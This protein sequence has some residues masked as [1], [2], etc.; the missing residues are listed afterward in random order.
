MRL[1]TKATVA[2]AL[3]L[4][5]SAAVLAHV[6]LIHPSNGAKLYWSSPSNISV[7]INDQGSDNITDGSHETA[8]RNAIEEWNKIEGTTLQLVENT[9]AASQARTDWES[10]SIHLLY[11]DENNSSGYFP[12]GSSTV[13]ITPVWFYS[14]GRISDA[15]VLFNGNSFSFTTSQ[16]SGRYDVQD[17]AVHELGHV[18]GLDHTGWAG[19]SMYPYV[20]STVIL[21]RSL[22]QDEWRGMRGIYPSGSHAS[23]SG[24]VRRTSD[25]SVVKGATVF[26]RDSNGRTA[27]AD[28]SSETGTFNI[29]GLPADTYTI[30]VRP[31]DYPV[32]SSNLGGSRTIQTDFEATV[33]GSQVVGAGQSQAIGD[34]FVG[35]DVSISLGRS[36][37]RYPLRIAAGETTNLTIRGNGLNAGSTLSCSDPAISIASVNWFGS[38]VT[39]L[40]SVPGGAA[41]G[42]VDVTVVDSVGDTSILPGGLEVT[43]PDP[44]VSLAS[45]NQGDFNGG[46]AVTISGTNFNAGARVVFGGEIYEDGAAGGCTVLNT[47][48]ISLTTRASAT[49]LTDVVV[50]D[51]SG[52]E[53]RQ[54]DGFQFVMA[55]SITTVFP[56][57]GST[58]GSTE[59]RINGENFDLASVVR[60]NGVNQAAVFPVSS[61]VLTVI[62]EVGTTGGPYLLE[63]ENPG[64]GIATSTFSYVAGPD[65]DVVSLTPAQGSTSGGDM[66]TISGAN[67][68]SNT[69]ILF[70]ADPN[71][72]AG[73][74]LGSV[75]TVLD[76]NT[77]EVTTPSRSAGMSSVIA[78]NSVT[79]QASVVTSGFTFQSEGGSGGGGGC[80]TVP[81]Q[82][83]PDWGE[84]MRSLIWFAL[85]AI[86]VRGMR[87]RA[88]VAHSPG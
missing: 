53:G 48:T 43:P 27:A 82:G 7:V 52:V 39:C 63:V 49:G 73:G 26:A 21:H 28:L 80:H 9:S 55:P 75:V 87:P 19:A 13:A 18:V 23:I 38:Q 32:S 69:S 1:P 86:G 78:T 85:L 16:V 29:K 37:D 3:T 10:N 88:V 67:F 40:V 34:V 50:I 51:A 66:I 22:S 70:G 5:G 77:L 61:T 62:S 25:S 76:A 74:S 30:Y 4:A 64:G 46:T 42:H 47:T 84:V 36:A 8:L 15:D 6:R 54:S 59:F 24:T 12:N 2:V 14:S 31:L 56:P 72:G 60:V 83:P 33:H 45:P 44:T 68:D 20:N 65:P 41:N 11:F 71:T 17:V 58:A 79:G 81:V 35:G 57:V